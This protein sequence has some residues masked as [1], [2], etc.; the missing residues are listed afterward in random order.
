MEFLIDT[1]LLLTFQEKVLQFLR[2]FGNGVS[3]CCSGQSF[4]WRRISLM[5][6]TASSGDFP[7]NIGFKAKNWILQFKLHSN[8][9]KAV[10]F[11][12]FILTLYWFA[13][14]IKGV[15]ITWGVSLI[16]SLLWLGESQFSLVYYDWGSH[17][18]GGVKIIRY[19]GTGMVAILA[20]ILAFIIDN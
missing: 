4:K 19:T 8:G 13:K 11:H 16:S 20:P 6:K 5:S 12:Q 10:L 17:N 18:L 3:S 9:F 2:N 7:S 15:I 1:R 14:L